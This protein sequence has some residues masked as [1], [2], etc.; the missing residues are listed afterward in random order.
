MI[1]LHAFP[2]WVYAV[3]QVHGIFFLPPLQKVLFVVLAVLLLFQPPLPLF[4][5][6]RTID[7]VKKPSWNKKLSAEI[8]VS[9]KNKAYS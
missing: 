8:F 7:S 4:Y 2:H 5:S 3:A 9:W 6:E 1:M